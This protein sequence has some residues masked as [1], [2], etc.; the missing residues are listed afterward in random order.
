VKLPREPGDAALLELGRLT[1]AAMN[2]EDV[3]YE[4]RRSLGPAPSNLARAPASAWI[5]DALKVLSNW[6][7]S[8][9]RE[10]ACRWF[11]AA[12]DA[13]E[14]RSSVLH[15][16]PGTW[17]TVADDGAVITHGPALEHIPVSPGRPFR[18]RSLTEGELR[19]V[20]EQLADARSGL[21]GSSI[22][23]LG[24]PARGRVRSRSVTSSRMRVLR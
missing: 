3:A 1:W 20:R 23:R 22:R 16:V 11:N 21:R 2:L 7:E 17:V 19:I 14:E 18:R 6:Q 24:A 10:S 5:K 12:R 4:M 13:L 15:S 9:I 8:E